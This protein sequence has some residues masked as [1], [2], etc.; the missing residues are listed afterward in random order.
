ML[1]LML[2]LAALICIGYGSISTAQMDGIT[3]GLV[4]SNYP[5]PFDSRNEN[6]TIVYSVAQEGNARMLIYDILGNLV[7]EYP[8]NYIGTGT[9]KVTWDG[10]NEAG[11]KVAK[12]GYI[13]V[14][15]IINDSNRILTVRKIGVIH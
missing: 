2:S 11:Q 6:T 1:K 13:C 10:T 3:L 5:N 15:E 4:V 14:V 7:K 8:S 12:G 9:S